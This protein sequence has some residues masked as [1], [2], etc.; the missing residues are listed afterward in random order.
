M[1]TQVCIS[2]GCE[3]PRVVASR[4]GAA[5]Y[6]VGPTPSGFSESRLNASVLAKVGKWRQPENHMT[7]LLS[8]AL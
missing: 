5:A 2:L 8:G 4:A 3:P 7:N 1:T 6:R